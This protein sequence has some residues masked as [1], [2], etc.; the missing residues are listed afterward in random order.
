MDVFP[1]AELMTTCM[2]HAIEPFIASFAL[3]HPAPSTLYNPHHPTTPY[4]LNLTTLNPK[5]P[6]NLNPHDPT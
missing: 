2:Q 1:R 3:V 5:T 6:K 4:T